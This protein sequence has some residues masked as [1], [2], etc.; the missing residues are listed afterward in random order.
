MNIDNGSFRNLLKNCSCYSCSV[1]ED[2]CLTS[3]LFISL[4]VLYQMFC[5]Y[6]IY[7]IYYVKIIRQSGIDCRWLHTCKINIWIFFQSWLISILGTSINVSECMASS[8]VM[9]SSLA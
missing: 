4:F 5:E 8:L 3:I 7:N 1:Y 9:A 6:F 2:M